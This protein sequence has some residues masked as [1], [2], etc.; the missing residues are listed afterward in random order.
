[1]QIIIKNNISPN[2]KTNCVRVFY[3][4][5]KQRHHPGGLLFMPEEGSAFN[6]V[7]GGLGPRG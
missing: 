5:M 2:M 1:M 7:V 6:Y 4:Y 3:A